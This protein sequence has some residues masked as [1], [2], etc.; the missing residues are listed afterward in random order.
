M[1]KHGPAGEGPL[2]GFV[3]DSYRRWTF[4]KGHV[5]RARGESLAVAAVRETQEEMGLRG[6]RLQE[7]LGT[8]EIWFRDQYEHK[9]A[10]VHKFITYYL[11]QAPTGARGRPEGRR[12][13]HRVIWVPLARIAI[14]SSYRNLQPIVKRA[15]ALIRRRAAIGRRV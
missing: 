8:T 7:R 15:A 12:R 11:M 3:M 6:L 10:L 14:T 2:V 9:G 1:W 5:R 13:I 4:A